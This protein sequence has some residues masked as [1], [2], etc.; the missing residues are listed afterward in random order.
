MKN[1]FTL[2]MLITFPTITNAQIF[3]CNTEKH[4]IHIY[5]LDKNNFEYKSWNKPK[6]IVEKPDMNLKSNNIEAVGSCQK[7]YKFRTGS[8]E[9]EVTNQWSCL[10]KGEIPPMEAKGATGDLYVRIKGDIKSHYYCLK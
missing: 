5:Q 8:T 6:A 10:S 4:I 9:F 1:I 3:V 7:Y 2:F